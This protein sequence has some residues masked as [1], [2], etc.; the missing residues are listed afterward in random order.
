VSELVHVPGIDFVGPLP[1]EV[2]HVTVFSCGI[3][4]ATNNP[5]AARGLVNFL[6]APIAD[7]IFKK[8]GLERP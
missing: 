7:P 4:A 6:T 1:P 3:H 5:D 8:H 2:Q